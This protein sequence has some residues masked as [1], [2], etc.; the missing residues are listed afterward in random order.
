M[1][2]ILPK[3]IDKMY[4]VLVLKLK[5]SGLWCSLN[6]LTLLKYMYIL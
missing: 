3:Y 6:I 5:D 4:F 2:K 1:V